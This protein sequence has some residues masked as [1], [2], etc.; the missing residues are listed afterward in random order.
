VREPVVVVGTGASGVHFAH[1]L[2]EAGRAVTILDVG[3]APPPAVLP[4]AHLD[5]LKRHLDDPVAY[6]LGPEFASVVMPGG[7]GQYY[8]FPPSKEYVFRD[9]EGLPR[10]GAGMSPLFSFAQGGLAEAWT[11]GCYPFT[12]EDLADYPFSYADLETGYVRVAERIG[13]SGTTDDLARFFPPHG[14]L[15]PPLDLDMHSRALLA[16]YERRRDW[17]RDELRCSVGRARVATLT[18]ERKDR[19]ACTYSG[20]CLWG[21]PTGA[22]YTPSLTLR[23]LRE[24]GRCRYVSGVRAVHFE[25]GDDDRI[26][27]LAVRRLADGRLE[28]HEVGTLVLAAGTLGSAKILLDSV[29]RTSGSTPKLSGLMDNRQVLMPFV[30]RKLV[31]RGWNPQSYQYHQLAIALDADDPRDQIH[32]LLTTLKTAPIHPVVKSVPLSVR[33]SVAV[34]RNVHAALGL[35]N[36]NHADR[37]RP[38]SYVTL[39]EGSRGDETTL[40]V[41][42]QPPAD[43]ESRVASSTQRMRRALGKLGCTAPRAMTHVRPMG[44][45]VHYA[46]T[47]PLRTDGGPFTS[48]LEGR[49]RPFRNLH[50]VDGSGFP[51]LPAKNLTFTLMAN[52]TRVAARLLET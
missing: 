48:T 10:R 3:H 40:V 4:D 34:V 17:L 25:Y 41:A 21:C 31:G 14:G 15:L 28:S 35:L 11:G 26:T 19:R 16:A 37:P 50:V 46:G 32:G 39:E 22:F 45:S 8:G 27:S 5:D 1:T 9:T 23:L 47:L 30:N 18:E 7:D 2:V 44:A 52:A 42:Y 38:G 43:D 24:S 13:I 6:F 36:V 51:S 12:E 33:S 49:C 29:R 20:R